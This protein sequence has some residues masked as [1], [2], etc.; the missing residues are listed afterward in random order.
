VPEQTRLRLR[1]RGLVPAAL[2]RA[3]ARAGV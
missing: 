3:G 2:Q 1:Q